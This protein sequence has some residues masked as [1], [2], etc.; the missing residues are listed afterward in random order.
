MSL[1]EVEE[2]ELPSLGGVEVNM[3]FS[4]DESVTVSLGDAN[5]VSDED[6]DFADWDARA[7]CRWFLPGLARGAFARFGRCMD[8]WGAVAM[9]VAVSIAFKF[10]LAIFACMWFGSCNGNMFL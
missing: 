2:D 10:E 9:D 1:D 7:C 5:G 8:W 6:D 3:T 4:C